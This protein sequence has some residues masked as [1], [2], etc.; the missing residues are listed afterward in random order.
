MPPRSQVRGGRPEYLLELRLQ[1]TP[2]RFG[3]IPLVIARADGT[4]TTWQEGLIAVEGLP[5]SADSAA[6]TIGGGSVDWALLASRG[7]D[8]ASGRATLWR[9]WAG[10][11]LEQAEVILVGAVDGP[12]FG[13]SN[14]PLTFTLQVE[15]WRD[16]ALLPSSSM[17]VDASTWPVDTDAVTDEP[18]LGAPYPIPIGRPGA[19][20][21]DIYGDLVDP[22]SVIAASPAYLVEYSESGI[23]RDLSK[24]L[25]SGVPIQAS[26]VW[27]IDVSDGL[28]EERTVQYAS[29]LRG[30]RVAY[31]DFLSATVIRAIAGHEYAVAFPPGEGGVLDIEV[32]DAA[33]GAGQV[34]QLLYGP[35]LSRCEPGAT[36]AIPIDRGRMAAQRA[37]L[38]RFLIDAVIRDSTSVHEWVERELAPFLP[39]TWVRGQAGWYWQAW[40]WDATEE[41]AIAHLDV[42]TGRVK[43]SSRM[44]AVGTEDTYS[45]FRLEYACGAD[46][47]PLR[48]RILAA[49]VDS[50]DART[51]A[52]WRCW[53]ARA[54]ERYRTGG[55]AAEWAQVC[56]VVQDDATADRIVEWLAARY[57]TPPTE[58][59]YEG[60]P[61]LE[62]LQIGDVVV[63]TDPD[64][65][66]SRRVALVRDILPGEVVRLDL[67]LL[68]E[69]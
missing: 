33:R 24:L 11:T 59:A 58:A 57:A 13:D 16:R 54:R 41:Q 64:I 49:E 12:E 19:A 26:S 4:S 50:N 29:D 40:R 63:V 46:G 3:S 15:A 56:P 20:A 22:E 23:A 52:N 42:G 5:R 34:L 21:W 51:R 31:V 68:Q 28:V 39:I 69:R 35:L 61:E 27:V 44:R 60:G 18:A 65:Y 66:I 43:R 7:Q 14:E 17:R 32:S 30:R 2:Y 48:R 36:V 37:Y 8:L 25:I 55:S 38:D 10:Q 53:Q 6:I 62:A 9:W 67:W 1:G 47:A 45:Q